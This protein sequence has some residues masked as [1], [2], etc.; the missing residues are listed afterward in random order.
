MLRD[1]SDWV[2]VTSRAFRVELGS[3]PVMWNFPPKGTGDS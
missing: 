3:D 1:G 2:P